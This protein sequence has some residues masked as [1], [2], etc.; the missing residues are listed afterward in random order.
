MHNQQVGQQAIALALA[1]VLVLVLV[2]GI[3]AVV[4]VQKEDLDLGGRVGDPRAR[5][6]LGRAVAVGRGRGVV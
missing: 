4:V 3:V 2:L 6:P 1:L 5:L